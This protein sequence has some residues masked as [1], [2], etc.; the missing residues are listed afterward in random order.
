MVGRP[1]GSR[2][3]CVTNG[4]CSW[5][6]AVDI[7]M[8]SPERNT[9]AKVNASNVNEELGQVQHGGIPCGLST[10]RWGSLVERRK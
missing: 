5:F 7:E 6:M 2:L 9:F 3:L 1:T 10:S 4:P 8:Y